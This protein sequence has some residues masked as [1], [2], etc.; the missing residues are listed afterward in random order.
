MGAFLLMASDYV[1]G[2]DGDFSLGLNE[3][4]IGL[5]LPKFA[6][7]LTRY[8]L[9]NNAIRSLALDGQLVSPQRALTLGL[10]DELVAQERT[11]TA[12]D[13]RLDIFKTIDR[14]AFRKTKRKLHS[15]FVS[16]FE[17]AI[18]SELEAPMV[19]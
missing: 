17:Q 16:A 12:V 4:A 2:V 18:L 3:V 14:N 5:E 9:G 7:E 11:G 6:M 10:L 13:R 1:I 19:A 8:R 15:E